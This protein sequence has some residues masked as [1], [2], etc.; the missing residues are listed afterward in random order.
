VTFL[1][2]LL[3]SATVSRPA[4][5]LAAY[6]SITATNVLSIGRLLE[7]VGVTALANV[8]TG[9]T[10]SNATYTAQLFATESF[11]SGALRLLSIQSSAPYINAGDGMDVPPA[12]LLSAT[13]EDGGPTGVGGFFA[14][15]GGAV[16]AANTTEGLAYSRTT[17]QVLAILYGG[18]GALA[19]A[20]TAKGGFFP[21]GVNGSINTI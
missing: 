6:G 13:A 9:L 17:S 11:H 15:T 7:D 5:N 10:T 2:N 12:D 16:A 21:S 20:G 3:G 1:Q 19:T 4:I 8:I 18:V 14:S